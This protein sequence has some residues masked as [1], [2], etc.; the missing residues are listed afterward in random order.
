MFPHS[1]AGLTF[2]LLILNFCVD[3]QSS[4]YS[5]S[6]YTIL[7]NM[8]NI[9]VSI[10]AAAAIAHIAAALP[11]PADGEPPKGEPQSNPLRSI[12]PGLTQYIDPAHQ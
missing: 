11:L 8:V 2:L 6:Y 5:L 10:L 9:N 1:S 4:S 3:R 7:F 12:N